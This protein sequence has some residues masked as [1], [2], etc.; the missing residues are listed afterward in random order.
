MYNIPGGLSNLGVEILLQTLH[1]MKDVQDIRQFLISSRTVIEV[2]THKLFKWSLSQAISRTCPLNY[3]PIDNIDVVCCSRSHNHPLSCSI[4]KDEFMS[5]FLD[6]L[7]LDNSDLIH[8]LLDLIIT[9]ASG[10]F[11][12][13]FFWLWNHSQDRNRKLHLC[14]HKTL[15]HVFSAC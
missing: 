3:V 8:L 9:C 12:A 7:T 5:Y 14:Y 13:L 6:H 15:C 1:E 2:Q 11:Y 4:L 10:L